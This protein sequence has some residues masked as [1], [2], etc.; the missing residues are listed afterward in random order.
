MSLEDCKELLDKL[1]Q[2]EEIMKQLD[3]LKKKLD[4]EIKRMIVRHAMFLSSLFGLVTL[5]IYA[6][7][8]SLVAQRGPAHVSALTTFL[9]MFFA[10]FIFWG[11]GLFIREVLK[12]LWLNDRLPGG[13]KHFLKK[14]LNMVQVLRKAKN[15]SSIIFQNIN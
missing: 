8:F 5:S 6:A 11:I 13:R 1:K 4:T 15:A 7:K 3:S 14:F 2:L 12:H 9:E 10:A